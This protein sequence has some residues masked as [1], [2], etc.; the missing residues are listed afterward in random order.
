V[1]RGLGG[2][3]ELRSRFDKFN[4]DAS[5]AANASAN[6]NDAAFLFGLI[7]HVRQEQTLAADND[8]FHG[9]GTAFV[10]RVDRLRLFVKRLLIHVR[11]VDEQR[12][13]VR[14]AQAIPAV[15]LIMRRFARPLRGWRWFLCAR[16]LALGLFQ[17]FPDA[18]QS[19]APKKFLIADP[20]ANNSV[21]KGVRVK[22][23][24]AAYPFSYGRQAAES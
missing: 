9:E 17:S 4:A 23:T 8:G 16:T 21:R 19:N 20:W 18:A 14:M 2:T 6:V 13:D 7:P 3:P 5:L 22:F 24:S 11:A 10:V 1:G 15:R 12:S